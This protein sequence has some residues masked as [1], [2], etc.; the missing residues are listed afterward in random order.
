MTAA[1]LGPYFFLFA[2]LA[3]C[4]GVR[5]MHILDVD[6]TW[7]LIAADRWLNG[8]RLYVD[9]METNPPLIVYFNALIVLLSTLTGLLSYD[10]Y[11][12]VCALLICL[13][14]YLASHY[15]EHPSRWVVI[16][17][18]V[19]VLLCGRDFGQ[20]EHLFILASWP[21][22]SA[23]LHHK[24]S[25]VFI[26]LMAAIGTALKPHFCLV[27]LALACGDGIRKTSLRAFFASHYLIIAA[28]QLLYLAAIGICLPEYFDSIVPLLVTHYAAH[29][30]PI[31]TLLQYAFPMGL[32]VCVLFG[33]YLFQARNRNNDVIIGL[34]SL[35]IAAFAI[36]LLQQKDYS[37]HWYPIRVFC[38]LLAAQMFF[39]LPAGMALKQAMRFLC[40][41]FVIYVTAPQLLWQ[42]R[43]GDG[44]WDDHAHRLAEMLEDHAKDKPVLPL[45][46]LLEAPLPIYISGAQLPYRYA[47]LWPLAGY[48]TSGVIDDSGY[49]IYRTPDKMSEGERRL[50]DQIIQD[51][52]HNPPAIITVHDGRY[53][54]Y[55]TKQSFR[56][57]YIGYFSQSELFANLFSQ[58]EDIGRI[59]YA[60]EKDTPRYQIIYAR[61]DRD[62][63]QP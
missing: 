59:H 19:L 13:S 61:K 47:H 25:S 23:L 7:L 39:S 60:T 10:I 34:F 6:H 1:R 42:Y 56:F 50:F 26:T 63:A 27:W 57:D 54:T 11:L 24:T 38:V 52:T 35:V 2:C 12:I 32:S 48:Y 29:N 30:E 49:M 33:V 36:M 15:A 62:D 17:S 5:F 55:P 41:L 58:Y 43:I 51:A 16:S 45:G 37:Y 44:T 46:F 14:T 9:I 21:L 8:D 4:V 28:V 3:L 18:L 20:R 53:G 40:L 31:F 22:L